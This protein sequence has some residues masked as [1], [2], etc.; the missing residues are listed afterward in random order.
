MLFRQHLVTRKEILFQC[1][2]Q[3]NGQ[4]ETFLWRQ[5][6]TGRLVVY[7]NHAFSR[8]SM[9]SFVFCFLFWLMFMLINSD[10]KFEINSL[11]SISDSRKWTMVSTA[12]KSWLSRTDLRLL[13]KSYLDI[14]VCQHNLE[15]WYGKFIQ[16]CCHG[17]QSFRTTDAKILNHCS[18]PQCKKVVVTQ[19]ITFIITLPFSPI[20]GQ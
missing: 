17:M 19:Q 13:W 4:K 11:S 16:F 10:G 6:R 12:T 9:Q 20:R 18:M 1:V 8:A 3:C 14:L 5:E 2:E 7:Q 15:T